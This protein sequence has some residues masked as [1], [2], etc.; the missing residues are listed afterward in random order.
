MSLRGSIVTYHFKTAWQECGGRDGTFVKTRA[1]KLKLGWPSTG[2]SMSVI[3]LFVTGSSCLLGVEGTEMVVQNFEG[4]VSHVHVG[5]LRCWHLL[6]F[7]EFQSYRQNSSYFQA[8]TNMQQLQVG[9][10]KQISKI[11]LR[12]FEPCADR[13]IYLQVDQH[14]SSSTQLPQRRRRALEGSS[15]R[16][17]P[18]SYG[19]Y[20]ESAECGRAQESRRKGERSWDLDAEHL[21]YIELIQLSGK[22]WHPSSRGQHNRRDLGHRQ[23]AGG[24]VVASGV[25]AQDWARSSLSGLR[26]C[27][28]SSHISLLFLVK[29]PKLKLDLDLVRVSKCPTDSLCECSCCC[30]GLFG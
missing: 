2:A 4:H 3:G 30:W 27:G 28:V 25:V 17:L 29:I 22:L 26:M 14:L 11:L 8:E 21:E 9:K 24:Q 20:L 7:F 19:G 5:I 18:L 12:K 10:K 6:A 13:F 23:A 15:G 1:Y 16:W